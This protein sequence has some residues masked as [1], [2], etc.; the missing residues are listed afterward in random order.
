MKG[1]IVVQVTT[2]IA[3]KFFIPEISVYPN[4][5]QGKFRLELNNFQSSHRSS[6]E[7]YTLHGEKLYVFEIK[8]SI[9][10]ID[11]S[12]RASGIYLLKIFDGQ[13]VFAEKKL[14]KW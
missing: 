10:E 5:S 1:T 14:L 7:V 4:P 11:L 9:S 2:D 3:E 6:L 8:N 12:N 13:K